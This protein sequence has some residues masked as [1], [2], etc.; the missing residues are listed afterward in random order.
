MVCGENHVGGGIDNLPRIPDE[1]K[2][3]VLAG[4]DFAVR[5]LDGSTAWDAHNVLDPCLYRCQAVDL[6]LDNDQRLTLDDR[7]YPKKIMRSTCVLGE[8]LGFD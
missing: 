7:I 2:L 4:Q 6:A 3:L 5:N 8:I 1:S